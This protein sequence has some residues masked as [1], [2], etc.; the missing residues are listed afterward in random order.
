[1]Q[2]DAISCLGL[3]YL[4]SQSL[5][6]RL[7]HILTH[8]HKPGTIVLLLAAHDLQIRGL[9]NMQSHGSH[10]SKALNGSELEGSTR[11]KYRIAAVLR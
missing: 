5:C 3:F 11:W 1:M 2:V 4:S 10:S 7:R 6:R 8:D 9:G